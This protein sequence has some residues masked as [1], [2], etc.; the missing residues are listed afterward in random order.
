MKVQD[1][2]DVQLNFLMAGLL[3]LKPQVRGEIVYVDD[4]EFS[5]HV[6]ATFKHVLLESRANLGPHIERGTFHGDYR[7]IVHS[8]LSLL[9]HDSFFGAVVAVADTPERALGFAV[10]YSRYGY[11]ELPAIVER[12]LP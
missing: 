7:A 1:L 2:S 9:Q 10:L 8:S 6:P 3:D 11:E 5:L 4:Q 12:M